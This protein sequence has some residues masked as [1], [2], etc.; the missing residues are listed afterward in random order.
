MTADART[1]ATASTRLSYAIQVASERTATDA[2]TVLRTLQTKFPKQ[3]GKRKP[4]ILR[5]DLGAEAIYYR[6]MVGPY[7][8]ME[9]ATALC[10][11]LKAAAR[12]HRPEKLRC[13]VRSPQPRFLIL[14]Q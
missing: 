8:S 3:L 11:T 10:S 12:L 13:A 5:T 4:I 7:A 14:T 1:A 2:H 9:E 6:V